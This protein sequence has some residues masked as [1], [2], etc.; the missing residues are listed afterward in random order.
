MGANMTV[1]DHDGLTPIDHAMKDR[2]PIVEFNASNPCEVYVWGT[3]NNY[4]LGTGNE[5]SR[6][7]PELLDAFRKQGISIKQ[8]NEVHSL[9]SVTGCRVS[10]DLI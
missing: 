7:Q 1:R 2:P 4:S 10:K 8:V 9:F 5:Q 3:N 6:S